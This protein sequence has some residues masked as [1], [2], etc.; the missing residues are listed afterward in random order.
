[1]DHYKKNIYI[2]SI[3]IRPLFERVIIKLEEEKKQ[4]TGGILLPENAREMPS[5]GKVLAIGPNAIEDKNNFKVGDTVL[6]MKY[7]GLKTYVDDVEYFIIMKNDIL[8]VIE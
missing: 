1:M 8:G 5:R 7:A 3:G 4:T 2:M 6:I